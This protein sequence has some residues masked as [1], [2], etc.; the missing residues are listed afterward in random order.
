Y[1]MSI[2]GSPKIERI[3]E[4]GSLVVCISHRRR[5]QGVRGTRESGAKTT[6]VVMAEV[7]AALVNGLLTCASGHSLHELLRVQEL[8][9]EPCVGPDAFLDANDKNR[10]PLLSSCGGRGQNGYTAAR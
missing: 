10:V 2:R 1:R 6:A 8:T 9:T 3:A 7:E 4:H 5:D